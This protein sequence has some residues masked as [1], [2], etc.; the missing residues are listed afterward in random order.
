MIDRDELYVGYEAEAPAGVAR[1][2]RR[3]IVGLFVL[4]AA[5]A[6]T[7]AAGQARFSDATFEF[8]NPRSFEGVVRAAPHPRLEIARPGRPGPG[9]E[10]VSSYTLVGLGKRGAD[11]AVEGL[12]GR[13]VVVDGTLIYRRG[14][15]I[16]EVSG[17]EVPGIEVSG[18]EDSGIGTLEGAER[19]FGTRTVVGEIVDSKCFLGVM[20]PG[21]R[22]IHRACAVRC[23]SGGIP[24]L[25]V[26]RDDSGPVSMMLL[27]DRD[28]GPIGRGILDRVA[29]PVAVTGDV[30]RVGDRWQIRAGLEDIRR[31][32]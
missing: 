13:H 5:I 17:I 28:G 9:V 30:M 1:H 24:P 31:L 16:I 27:L 8:G 19:A 6:M 15:T 11:R 32:E 23:L 12:D 25:L 18:A 10:P 4:A 21:S 22:K 29:R 14:E 26:V 2:V 7:L 3:V 20:K